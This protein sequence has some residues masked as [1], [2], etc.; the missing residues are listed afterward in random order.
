MWKN[1][2]A[3]AALVLSV[4]VSARL[5]GSANA[6]IGPS[7]QY[8]ANP[9]VNF[10]G[11]LTNSPVTTA[12]ADQDL[13]ITTII[14]NGSCGIRVGNT[15]VLETNSY[16]Y[17]TYIYTRAG[18][19]WAATNFTTGNARLKIPA[20]QDFTL[21]NCLGNKFYVEGHYVRP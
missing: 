12:P 1:I 3:L 20:G 4:G 5:I 11:T 10:G 9:I 2:L 15:D 16:F 7:V 21:T 19:D 13:I 14:T 17:P 18:Y 8:A 6:E